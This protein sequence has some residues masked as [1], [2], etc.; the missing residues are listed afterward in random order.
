MILKL[1]KKP[2]HLHEVRMWSIDTYDGLPRMHRY[3]YH[4][5]TKWSDYSPG[6]DRPGADLVDHWMHYEGDRTYAAG[7]N[8]GWDALTKDKE[9][10]AKRF[11]TEASA[12]RAAIVRM[13]ERIAADHRQLAEHSRVLNLMVRM[14]SESKR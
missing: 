8:C 14:L 7:R 6:D 13:N 4:V 5:F 2:K 1:P 10:L 12:L 9:W 3:V 11:A